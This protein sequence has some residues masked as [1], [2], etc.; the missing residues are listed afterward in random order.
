MFYLNSLIFINKFSTTSSMRAIVSENTPDFDLF[1]FSLSLNNL[2]YLFEKFNSNMREFNDIIAKNGG[3][4]PFENLRFYYLR[5]ELFELRAAIRFKL[6]RAN[7]ILDEIKL[8]NPSFECDELLY[9][10]NLYLSNPDLG[11]Y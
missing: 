4:P 7:E 9:Y 11:Y 2:V 5:D 1:S 6:A 3:I 8:T 10:N